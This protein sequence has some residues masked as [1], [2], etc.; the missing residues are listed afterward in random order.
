MNEPTG[1][2]GFATAIKAIEGKWKVGVS[3]VRPIEAV[4]SGD[5]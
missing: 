4:H 1:N 2:C 3:Q 5:Q